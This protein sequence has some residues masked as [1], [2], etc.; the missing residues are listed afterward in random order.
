M[1]AAA[2]FVR[3]GI[4]CITLFVLAAV[5]RQPANKRYYY[6]PFF[7][8]FKIRIQLIANAMDAREMVVSAEKENVV[9]RS[10]CGPFEA[11]NRIH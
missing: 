9:V 6:T 10:K 7:K 2:D 11:P 1:L 5:E 4:K 8:R 3:T